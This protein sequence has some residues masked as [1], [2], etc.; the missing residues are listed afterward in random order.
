MKLGMSECGRAIPASCIDLRRAPDTGGVAE[1]TDVE[2][3]GSGSEKNLELRSH[4]GIIEK[5]NT[6]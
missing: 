2:T 4:L 5:V 3:G 6:Q 1:P